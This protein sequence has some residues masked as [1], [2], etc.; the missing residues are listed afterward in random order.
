MTDP[1]GRG[2][3]RSELYTY[4]ATVQSVK[5]N[6]MKPKTKHH[7]CRKFIPMVSAEV[8]FHYQGEPVRKVWLDPEL[9]WDTV[10]DGGWCLVDDGD[11]GMPGFA[12]EQTIKEYHAR[13]VEH[14]MLDF[15]C[16]L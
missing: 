15:E 6:D 5:A 12:I 14:Q 4:Y 2:K 10:R 11:D 9:Y 8:K 7:N 1:E 16:A 13:K 3:T